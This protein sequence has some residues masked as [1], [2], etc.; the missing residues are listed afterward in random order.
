MMSAY[1][2]ALNG[3]DARGLA[4]MCEQMLA[5]DLGPMMPSGPLG[6]VVRTLMPLV[7]S[8]AQGLADEGPASDATDLA[9]EGPASD[10]ADLAGE[11]PAAVGG[12]PA[13]QDGRPSAL[14]ELA[15]A[16]SALS[17]PDSDDNMRDIVALLAE[18]DRPG[19][20]APDEFAELLTRLGDPG[21][22]RS[23]VINSC[24][25]SARWGSES[26]PAVR[27]NSRRRCG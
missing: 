12:G 22:G 26:A 27:R 11:E 25:H 3:G 5:G 8:S 20:L 23:P 16:V 7:R 15:R 24:P 19:V 17:A 13:A 1:A 9:G 2:E 18:M 4:A 21:Q 10:A 6:S 14:P